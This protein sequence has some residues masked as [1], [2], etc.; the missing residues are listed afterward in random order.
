MGGHARTGREVVSGATGEGLAAEA[1]AAPDAV[2]GLYDTWAGSG[3]YDRDVAE[4]GYEAP[5]RVAAMVASRL[6]RGGTVL[7]AG[8]GTGRV[9]AAL[10]AAGVTGVV[11]GDFSPTSLEAASEL[12]VYSEVQHLDLNGPLAFSD[13][14]FDVTVSVGVFSYLTDTAATVAEL[15]RVVRP[16]GAVIFTQRTDL[17][18]DRDGDALIETLVE[19]GSC[20]ADV[21]EVSPYLPGHPDFRDAIGIRYVTLSKR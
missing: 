6:P 2:V 5:E 12:G 9:G 7:D 14:Q 3:E 20:T 4:W 16:G 13:A 1:N 18:A 17:W 19:S 8:C 10:A 15:L 11:G 21:S